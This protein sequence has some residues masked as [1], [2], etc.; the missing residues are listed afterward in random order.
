M[1]TFT[2][3]DTTELEIWRDHLVASMATPARTSHP[4]TFKTANRQ[5]VQLTTL[6][7]LTQEGDHKDNKGPTQAPRR[8]RKRIRETSTTSPKNS[9]MGRQKGKSKDVFDTDE[10]TSHQSGGDTDQ[11]IKSQT[12]KVTRTRHTLPRRSTVNISSRIRDA[13]ADDDTNSP[14]PEASRWWKPSTTTVPLSAY[15]RVLP[16]S[17]TERAKK[18]IKLDLPARIRP[19]TAK[20]EAVADMSRQ[21][22]LLP[23]NPSLPTATGN[24][25]GPT[26]GPKLNRP[27]LELPPPVKPQADNDAVSTLNN[28]VSGRGRDSGSWQEKPGHELTHEEVVRGASDT[29]TTQAPFEPP[30][31][32]D[33]VPPLGQDDPNSFGIGMQQD[34]ET[35]HKSEPDSSQSVTESPGNL[36]VD[37]PIDV[38]IKPSVTVSTLEAVEDSVENGGR[39]VALIELPLRPSA[40]S[41]AASD[42]RSFFFQTKDMGQKYFSLPLK[43]ARFGYNKDEV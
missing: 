15:K 6:K 32:D 2:S 5:A 24:V 20:S 26:D 31:I 39:D 35:Q 30:T 3:L 7:P 10:E 4:F 42:P 21:P 23:P 17:D 16:G 27:K 41:G 1:T 37:A 9:R 29:E 33:Q 14:V 12:K 22:V 18:R 40:K 8:S 28:P 19:D 38:A 43:W 34:M 13:L 25:S 11:S 36:Q